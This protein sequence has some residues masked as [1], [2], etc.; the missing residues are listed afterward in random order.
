MV[1]WKAAARAGALVAAAVVAG[2]SAPAVQGQAGEDRV[3]ARAFDMLAGRGTEIGVSVREV[4]SASGL[5][6]SRAGVIVADV[7]ADGPAAKAGV[8]KG[9]VVVEFDGERVRSVR[10]FTRLVQETPTGRR[11]PAALMR[12]GQRVSVSV[13]PRAGSAIRFAGEL[14]AARIM[15]DLGRD[16][17]DNF[18]PAP[19]RPPA[20]PS[21]P[22]APPVPP[23]PVVP[24]M[25]T[26]IWRSQ[27]ALGVTVSSL[28]DQLAEYFGVKAGVLVTAVQEGSAAAAAGFKAGD[29]VTT[30][31]GSEVSDPADLRRRSATLEDGA[32]FTAGIMREKKALTLKGKVQRRSGTRGV[33]RVSDQAPAEHLP[34]RVNNL[35]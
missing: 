1:S 5:A 21:A 11:V 17:G 15:R 29:V 25:E 20:A 27:G 18:P 33:T 3:R 23:V 2:V 35:A 28:S 6:A 14:D 13:E 32:E 4:E 30:L 12:D 7:V 24:D 26:F 19:P 9:D 34:I 31:N 10:Q 16:F 8:R 22:H